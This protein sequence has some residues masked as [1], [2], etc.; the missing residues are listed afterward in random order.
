MKTNE[1]HLDENTARLLRA[2]VG[3]EARLSPK[4]S[5]QML[6]RLTLHLRQQSSAF[7]NSALAVLGGLVA[8]VAVWWIGRSLPLNSLTPAL[9]SQQ[10]V[11]FVGILNLIMVPFAGLVIIMRRRRDV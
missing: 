3:D 5:S 7:P 6:A 2:A 10:L 8:M 4:L 9:A 1:T 11:L